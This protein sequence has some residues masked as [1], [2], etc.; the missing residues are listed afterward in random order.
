MRE[1]KWTGK[2][3]H[4]FLSFFEFVFQSC[5]FSSHSFQLRLGING[6]KVEMK[7]GNSGGNKGAKGKVGNRRG[8]NR[9]K[10]RGT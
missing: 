2:M 3:A 6:G 9:E 7:R 1:I 10:T 4:I 5:S 8:E